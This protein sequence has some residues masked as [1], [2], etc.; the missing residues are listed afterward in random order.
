M[1]RSDEAAYDIRN[2]SLKEAMDGHFQRLRMIKAS[3]PEYLA[4]CAR[5]FLKGL[6]EQCPARSWIENGTLDS[7]VEYFCDV[8]HAL[9]RELGLL[10]PGEKGWEVADWKERVGGQTKAAKKGD[11]HSKAEKEYLGT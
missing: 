11:P 4:R 5:C 6:C 8:A 2:G 9:A 3:R 10:G 1:L 7:P